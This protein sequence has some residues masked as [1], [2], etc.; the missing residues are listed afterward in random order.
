[1]AKGDKKKDAT[2]GGSAKVADPEPEPLQDLEIPDKFVLVEDEI[3][4]K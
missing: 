2:T 4:Q 1:M 3:R